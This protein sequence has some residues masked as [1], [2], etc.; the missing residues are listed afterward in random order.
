M[1]RNWC[2][3]CKCHRIDSGMYMTCPKCGIC[4]VEQRCDDS[5]DKDRFTANRWIKPYKKSEHLKRCLNKK[6][7]PNYVKQRIEMIFHN[8]CV[9]IQKIYAD[10]RK[11]FPNYPFVIRKILRLI[12]EK[13]YLHLFHKLSSTKLQKYHNDKWREL[14]E[15]MH[16][17]FDEKV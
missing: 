6:K 8:I 2:N 14:C 5:Y 1:D 17:E 4:Y 16:Y 13:Q 11:S 10:E 9:P 12:N 15:R 3:K 7:I